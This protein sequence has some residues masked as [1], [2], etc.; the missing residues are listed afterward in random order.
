MQLR[1]FVE[2]LALQLVLSLVQVL[3][4]E[5]CARFCGRFAWLAN[6][7]FKFRHRVIDENIL[8]V[9]PDM[10]LNERRKISLKMW[11]HLFLMGC[12]I[13]QAPR[14]IHDS[15]WR[16]HVFIRNKVQM[17]NYLIDY[18]PLVCVSGHLGNFEM[19]GFITGLLGMPSYTVARKLD[20]P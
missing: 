15:N 1:I 11:Y 6:D 20:N 9:F 18:R 19:A 3:P 16:R 7:V 17:T 5:T 14:K 13:A 10:P 4:I 12:E 2:Y 8:G